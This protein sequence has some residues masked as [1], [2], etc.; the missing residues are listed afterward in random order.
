M[1]FGSRGPTPPLLR[2]STYGRTRQIVAVIGP[3]GGGKSTL[4]RLLIGMRG[5]AGG[6]YLDGCVANGTG[7]ISH[8]I[9]ASCRNTRGCRA[10]RWRR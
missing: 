5:R 8:G 6:V 9:S 7:G 3:S 10:A 1:A 2:V 4:L